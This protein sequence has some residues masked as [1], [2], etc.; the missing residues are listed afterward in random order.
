MPLPATHGHSIPY[1][2]LARNT[3]TMKRLAVATI[4]AATS[5]FA[6]AATPKILEMPR[7]GLRA[8]STLGMK[9]LSQ[10]RRLEDNADDANEDNAGANEE[11]QENQVD[12]TW[13]KNFSI[14]FQGCHYVQQV[15]PVQLEVNGD[16][17]R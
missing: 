12:M 10:A 17:Y 3:A 11:E 14:K 6:M 5:A 7:G 8:D 16:V 2:L 15:S 1:Y 4:L 9:L 13:V